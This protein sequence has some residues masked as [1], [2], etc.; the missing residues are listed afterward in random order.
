VILASA[1]ALPLIAALSSLA[2]AGADLSLRVEGRA[3]GLA[4]QPQPEE[5]RTG[6]FVTP[7]ALLAAEGAAIRGTGLYSA[8]IWTTSVETRAT[9]LVNHRAEASLEVA[10]EGGWRAVLTA[11]GARGRTDPLEP[12]GAPATP[13]GGTQLPS[14]GALAFE[15]FHGALRL[16]APLGERAT[17]A[18]EASGALSR[19][20][21]PA[22]RLVLPDQRSARL[23]AE[24]SLRV[25]ERDELRF[26][27]R[28]EAAL[29]EVTG[30]GSRSS[31]AAVSG[32]WTR[33]LATGLQARMGAGASLYSEV[34]SERST[35]V[36]PNG[37][38]AAT[39]AGGGAVPTGEGAVR[40]TTFVDRF[41]GA[42]LPM[43][44]AGVNLRWATGADHSLAA[45]IS[46]GAS[47]DGTTTV[48]SAEARWSA[49]LRVDLVLE[50]GCRARVQRDSRPGIPS[51]TEGAA[52]MAMSWRTRRL[53]GQ[54]TP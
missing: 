46:G 34:G 31:V 23:L 53:V 2:S 10:P 15:E 11:A 29:T 7:S 25:T 12:V 52:F 24:L 9:P 27:A 49:G 38:C 45:F 36:L 30:S 40:V 41:T 8:Q 50:V 32:S 43:S 39:W 14:A 37:E 54:G 3:T 22:G 20:T 5:Y 17:L 48:G 6:Y 21:E 44:E 13:G 1:L 33:Q 47:L 18:T 16:E 19:A 35:H 42:V 28:G 26:G 4:E 51:F